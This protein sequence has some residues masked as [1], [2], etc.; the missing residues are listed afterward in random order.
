MIF[1]RVNALTD[2]GGRLYAG[3]YWLVWPSVLRDMM[4]GYEAYGLTYRGEANKESAREYILKV[5]KDNGR[6]SVYCLNDTLNNSI[7][8]VNNVAG[9]LHAVGSKHLKN[10]VLRIDFIE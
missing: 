6:A 8:K 4:D 5:I 3:D 2:S 1:Q 7:T 9:P 10:E